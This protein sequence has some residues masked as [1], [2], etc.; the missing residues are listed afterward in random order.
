[1]NILL[2]R[3]KL[4][5]IIYKFNFKSKNKV[6]IKIIYFIV[7][8]S[9][10]TFPFI[11]KYFNTRDKEPFQIISKKYKFI[12]IENPLAASETMQSLLLR[13][14]EINLGSVISYQ[15]TKL[16]IGREK[17]S[18]FFKFSIIRNPWSRIVSCYNKK[19][20]NATNLSKISLLSQY[21][22]LY[23][24]MK[25]NNFI[26]WLCSKEGQDKYADPHW[27]SQYKILFDDLEE[28][29]YDQVVKLENFE[30]DFL[31]IRAHLNFIPVNFQH[32]GASEEQKIRPLFKNWKDYFKKLDPELLK[33]IENRYEKDSELFNYP[34]LTSILLE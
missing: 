6:I 3:V 17:F 24:M 2:S 10:L 33:K 25:F 21:K 8:K 28:P 7:R 31:K 15:K 12:Y 1:M 5:K 20:M 32:K 16:L 4:Y 13:N 9:Y 23:P 19:I 34:K 22:G 29:F 27:K 14:P 30:D 18:L 26:S 11:L